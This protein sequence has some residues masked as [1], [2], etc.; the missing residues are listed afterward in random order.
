MA[1]ADRQAGSLRCSFCHKSSKSVGKLIS[2]PND[3][4]RAYICDE[5][6]A[7]CNS[8]LED[9]RVPLPPVSEMPVRP[10]EKHPLLAHPLASSLL[11]A[12]EQWVKR[13]STGS[14]ASPELSEVRKIAADMMTC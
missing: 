5:C 10:S 13:E 12:I 7:V 14:D 11:Q 8:I 3:D 1:Q 4:P 6:I 2:T 9:D